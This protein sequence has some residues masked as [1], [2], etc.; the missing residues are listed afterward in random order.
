MVDEGHTGWPLPARPVIAVIGAGAIGAYYGGR[1][2]H[3]GHA[4]HFL[5]RSDYEHVRAHGW[6]IRSCDGD[7]T[8]PAER[9]HVYHDPAD[10]PRADLVLITLKTTANDQLPA[11]VRPLLKEQTL[12]LTLQNGLGGDELLAET[13][14]P[15]RV[16]G[17]LAFICANRGQPGEILHL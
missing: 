15:Q 8:L 10:M 5:L 9:L 13:F 1:L 3:A 6:T 16:L 4:V 2:A 11:L 12:L 17:G 14:G 7:F